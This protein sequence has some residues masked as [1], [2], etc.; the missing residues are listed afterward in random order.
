MGNS[1]SN[2]NEDNSNNN[3]NISVSNNNNNDTN[4]NINVTNDNNS[5]SNNNN[6]RN[7][8]VYDTPTTVN[9][10]KALFESENYCFS[11]F[12]SNDHGKIVKKTIENSQ[13][14]DNTKPMHLNGDPVLNEF[15]NNLYTIFTNF[16][17]TNDISKT[18]NDGMVKYEIS[19][20]Q[21]LNF[22]TI[23]NQCKSIWLPRSITIGEAH[24]ILSTILYSSNNDR[25]PVDLADYVLVYENIMISLENQN[26]ELYEEILKI[27]FRLNRIALPSFRLLII[28]KSKLLLLE[29]KESKLLL[30]E[31]E[32]ISI[33]QLIMFH[34]IRNNIHQSENENSD[35]TKTFSTTSKDQSNEYW[36][37]IEVKMGIIPSSQLIHPLKHIIQTNDLSIGK[38][39]NFDSCIQLLDQIFISVHSD[40]SH[41]KLITP[42][43]S[44]LVQIYDYPLIIAL[45]YDHLLLSQFCK[46]RCSDGRWAHGIMVN[47]KYYS[48][49][50]NPYIPMSELNINPGSIIHLRFN[51]Q[52]DTIINKNISSSQTNEVKINECC[53]EMSNVNNNRF[54][55][56]KYQCSAECDNKTVCLMFPSQ[57]IDKITSQNKTINKHLKSS[58]NWIDSSTKINELKK[59]MDKLSIE[60]TDSIQTVSNQI[61]SDDRNLVHAMQTSLSSAT[62]INKASIFSLPSIDK[63]ECL[64][65]LSHLN[66]NNLECPH[67]TQ[68]FCQLCIQSSYDDT[69]RDH[70]CPKCHNKVELSAYRKS[71]IIGKYEKEGISA[72]KCLICN[73]IPEKHRLCLD[74][75]CSALFCDNC[76]KKTNEHQSSTTEISNSTKSIKCPQ[77]K[78]ADTYISGAVS[79]YIVRIIEYQIAQEVE[80]NLGTSSISKP[81]PNTIWK[82]E[83]FL[84]EKGTLEE[85][86]KRII[87]VIQFNSDH[88]QFDNKEEHCPLLIINEPPEYI[89][90]ESL[91]LS[92]W[93]TIDKM[94]RWEDDKNVQFYKY[95]QS[96]IAAYIPHF[97]DFTARNIRFAEHIMLDTAFL[98]TTY[99]YDFTTINDAGRTFQRGPEPYKRPCGWYR[100]AIKVLGTYENSVWLG[101]GT[102]AWP[103]AYHGTATANA[104]SILRNGLIAG[105]SNG[106]D[107]VGSNGAVHGVGIYLSP[108]PL[109]SSHRNYARL[110]TVDDRQYQIMFQVR[111]KPDPD[112]LAKHK[113]NIWRCINSQHVRPYGILF[114]ETQI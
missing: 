39:M 93:N 34:L 23:D 108:D 19:S 26:K 32:S 79:Y 63:P 42:I 96:S 35:Y 17:S 102:D 25:I 46:I 67:C 43:I 56:I 73:S 114:K 7:K 95:N 112:S 77:C 29:R 8:T 87:S 53:Q 50:Q 83:D 44:K 1:P 90:P 14:Q 36:P 16:L 94:N 6:I 100:K 60:K 61:S 80:S 75:N 103:V 101:T 82:Q 10:L 51:F 15:V 37:I 20:V 110:L 21:S 69:Q 40:T 106:I 54:K 97:T 24:R 65:C 84:P 11:S 18:T 12:S 72:F 91:R 74:S 28:H 45:P 88:I 48:L 113:V 22:A 4:N 86:Y 99:D 30:T 71:R 98:D 47:G 31:N 3:N 38:K 58:N 68:V 70:C 76:C 9:I 41:I 13:Q 89:C 55:P 57:A 52:S 109:Y 27:S 64:N 104:L 105:G 2:S 85:N 49:D 92:Y 59:Q 33:L 111:V 78:T 62:L 5:L 81:L 107:E 66:D